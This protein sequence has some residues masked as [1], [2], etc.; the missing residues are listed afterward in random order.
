MRNQ[1]PFAW[2]CQTCPEKFKTLSEAWAHKRDAHGIDP[3]TN[4]KAA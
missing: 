2:G 1:E 3:F 4:R